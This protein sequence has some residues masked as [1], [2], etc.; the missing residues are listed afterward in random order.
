MP[1]CLGW[2]RE[3]KGHGEKKQNGTQGATFV[4]W[5]LLS[6]TYSCL[7]ESLL[8]PEAVIRPIF[9]AGETKAEN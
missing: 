1:M 7:T 2:S 3:G 8:R 5:S 4:L 9:A 6:M